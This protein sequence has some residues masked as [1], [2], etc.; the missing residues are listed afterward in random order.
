MATE[1]ENKYNKYTI[2]IRYTIEKIKAAF[3]LVIC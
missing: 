2:R 1:I 3:L